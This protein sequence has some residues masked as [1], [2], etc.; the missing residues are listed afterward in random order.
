MQDRITRVPQPSADF[1]DLKRPILRTEVAIRQFGY[2]LSGAWLL[3]LVQ[4]S[5]QVFV[6]TGIRIGRLAHL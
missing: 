4:R 2:F 5:S 1:S 6:E 3:D